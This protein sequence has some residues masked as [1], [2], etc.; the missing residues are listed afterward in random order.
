MSLLE[1]S[2]QTATGYTAP[3]GDISYVRIV[4]EVERTGGG[5]KLLR[6]RK[7]QKLLVRKERKHWY[8]SLA[9][10]GR[11]I[12]Y[13]V[14]HTEEEDH[15]PFSGWIASRGNENLDPPPVL[16]PVGLLV[17]A[18]QELETLQHLLVA[19]AI[20]NKIVERVLGDKTTHPEVLSRS[21]VLLD[22]LTMMCDRDEHAR[23][24]IVSSFV[25]SF[26][27]NTRALQNN[28]P[29]VT[30]SQPRMPVSVRAEGI[31]EEPSVKLCVVSQKIA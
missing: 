23:N 1:A 27:D 17:P 18:E 11:D 4:P 6:F 28:K 22:F 8:L 26:S 31:C 29:P 25:Y 7:E 10:T 9:R 20:Q 21:K 19:W 15:P 13:Y 3:G 24:Y 14:H 2:L 16:Q 30:K 12:D 5:R